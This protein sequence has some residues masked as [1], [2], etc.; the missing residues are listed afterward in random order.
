MNF[1]IPFC[2]YLYN[3]LKNNNIIMKTSLIMLIY[4]TFN[5]LLSYC[6]TNLKSNNSKGKQ[7]TKVVKNDNTYNYAEDS[8]NFF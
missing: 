1:Y 4:F 5:Y 8:C 7:V 3:I 2:L 6:N